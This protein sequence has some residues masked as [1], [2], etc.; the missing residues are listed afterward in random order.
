[1]N[2]LDTGVGVGAEYERWI[3]EMETVLKHKLDIRAEW[4]RWRQVWK[5][6]AGYERW[7]QELDTGGENRSWI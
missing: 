2:E 1:M 5:P 4:M 7:R 3:R 6:G